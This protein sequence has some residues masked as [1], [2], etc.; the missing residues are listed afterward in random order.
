M[1]FPRRFVA[2]R[3]SGLA[4]SCAVLLFCTAP[5]LGGDHNDSPL[6]R[7]NQSADLADVYVFPVAGDNGPRVVMMMT[8]HPNAS[9]PSQPNA[10]VPAKQPGTQFSD[11][12]EYVFRIRPA[13]IDGTTVV[14]DAESEASITC[15]FDDAIFQ[16]VS[17]VTQTTPAGADEPISIETKAF[18]DNPDGGDRDDFR[19][20]AGARADPFFTDPGKL[21]YNYIKL[22]EMFTTLLRQRAMDDTADSFLARLL[23]FRRVGHME[24]LLEEIEER[25]E[26]EVIRRPRDED[27]A[28]WSWT[29]FARAV[30]DK[31]AQWLPTPTP[32]VRYS[33]VLAIVVEVDLEKVYGGALENTLLALAAETRKA[34]QMID[35]D[36]RPT[37]L[38][39]L[40]AKSVPFPLADESIPRIAALQDDWNR[41]DTFALSEELIPQYK[42]ALQE[43][44]TL[45]DGSDGE[46]DW[47][48]PHPL[49]PVMMLDVFL[50][51][52]A[53][54]TTA[55]SSEPTYFEIEMSHYLGRKPRT[56]GG[57]TPNDD[58]IDTFLTW[59]VNGPE[60]YN[61]PR[62]TDG[63]D[64]PSKPA[65]D[66]F[67]YLRR[68]H[69]A[70]V[71][72]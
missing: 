25:N 4:V 1:T 51:D 67:P 66:E 27:N 23:N 28:W 71:N 52:V 42:A 44:M 17:C 32:F 68:P 55:S 40:F 63:E 16:V 11:V 41:D 38:N 37:L 43:G 72:L 30:A 53:G 34:G 50:V 21:L 10:L 8:V 58:S 29:H 70:L 7:A 14:T 22:P 62:R 48:T 2:S 12:V 61:N 36:A 64:K 60:R 24:T 54:S 46:M 13:T 5:L 39:L 31:E 15:T 45:Y 19:V 56:H 35:R 18:V 69:A 3:A 6:T 47:P 65:V 57:R 20:F 49:L 59:F 33:N 9:A 26:F